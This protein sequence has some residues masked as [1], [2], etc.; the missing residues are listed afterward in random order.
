MFNQTLYVNKSL[1]RLLPAILFTTLVTVPN[2]Y[3]DKNFAWILLGQA[4]MSLSIVLA[5]SLVIFPRYASIEIIDR[6]C[7]NL[8]STKKVF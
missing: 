3:V 8:E 6:F 4:L 5:V 7:Y 2:I 1:F